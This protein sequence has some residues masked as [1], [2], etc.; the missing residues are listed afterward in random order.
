MFNS[1][2]KLLASI[3]QRPSS[4]ENSGRACELPQVRSA[5]HQSVRDC[6]GN[7]VARLN[8]RIAQAASHGELWAL[9]TE[10]YQLIATCHCQSVAVERIRALTPL[11]EGPDPKPLSSGRRPLKAIP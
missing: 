10:A 6:H 1:L 7:P 3:R 2:H 11:F 9:R 5:M 8:A 4:S